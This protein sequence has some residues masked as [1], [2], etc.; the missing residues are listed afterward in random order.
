MDKF[1]SPRPIIYLR[2]N[3]GKSGVAALND[4][5]QYNYTELTNYG[6]P[7]TATD[8]NEPS[9]FYKTPGG[10]WQPAD[11]ALFLQNKQVPVSP[12]G[13]PVFSHG[14]PRGKD[15]FIMISAGA[16]R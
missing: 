2:A 13:N 1:P 8:P 12:A 10:A 3:V 15:Q 9:D 14:T 11:Y 6:L 16:D 7:R 5:Y 4:T